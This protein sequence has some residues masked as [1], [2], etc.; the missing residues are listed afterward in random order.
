MSRAL[1]RAAAEPRVLAR[2]LEPFGD[3]GRRAAALLAPGLTPE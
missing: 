2:R 3:L 1:H